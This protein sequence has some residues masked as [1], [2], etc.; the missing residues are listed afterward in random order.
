MEINFDL[1]EKQGIAFESEA[2]E[3]LY[4]G[5]A[6]GGKSHLMRVGLIVWSLE[7]PGLQSYIFR[8]NRTDLIKNHMEGPK[9][10]RATLAPM[11]RAGLCMVVEDEI[12]FFNG[13]PDAKGRPTVGSKIYLCH[14][15]N[16]KDVFKYDGAEIHVLAVDEGTHFTESMYTFLRH[17]VRMVGLADKL[18]EHYK[19][20]FPRILI[21]S[22]PGNIGHEWVKRTFLDFAA[23]LEIKRAS[24]EQG[25]MLRQFI[26]ALL[27]DNPS[28]TED[29]PEYEDRLH[30]LDSDALVQAKRYGN[31]DIIAGAFFAGL[32]DR[33]TQQIE[34]FEIPSHWLRFRSMDWGYGSPFS[35]GWWAVSDGSL[36][37]LPSGDKT[38]FPVGAIIRYREWYGATESGKGLRLTN[39][40]LA[41]GIKSREM[42]DEKITYSHAGHDTF[43]K[44]KGQGISIAEE[45]ADYDVI[46]SKANN[47]RI[48]GWQQVRS[49]LKGLETAN[50][51]YLP[52]LY[53]FSTCD[54]F[55]PKMSI[56]QHDDKRGEDAAQG[57]DHCFAGNTLVDTIK[58]PKQIKDIQVGELVSTTQGYKLVSKCR[59]TRK[60]VEIVK[61][62]FKDGREVECT[63]DH[64]FLV[65]RLTKK[66]WIE[67]QKMLKEV[68][69][70]LKDDGAYCIAVEPAGKADVWC[71][72]VPG[73][74]NFTVYNGIVVHNCPEEVRYACMSRPWVVPKRHAPTFDEKIDE[75]AK[76]ID[77]WKPGR[78]AQH[79]YRY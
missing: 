11:V 64:Q 51:K 32:I 26:P 5:A 52:M 36:I 58:G 79:E 57:E 28:M 49:R 50:G 33:T 41:E 68:S 71:L 47:E 10:F 35:I 31:W 46:W 72:S 70:S 56:L 67:A 63:P 76:V 13:E 55:F 18:P 53:V 48:N 61:L 54:K 14:C 45:M 30:G 73:P 8:R 16:E 60:N 27:E 37:T 7:I 74:E 66:K 21:G 15:D 44:S 1:H 38:V 43:D 9:G 25:G 12:R 6:G 17:R 22:N 65:L 62:R 77:D 69:V 19:G 59:Q 3:I 39:A 4:G 40:E 78:R 29:D 23:P 42:P 24:R 34:P 20:R 2:T 75:A